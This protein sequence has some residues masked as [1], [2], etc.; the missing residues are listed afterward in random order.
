[1]AAAAA[2]AAGA[3]QH[4]PQRWHKAAHVAG[5]DAGQQ[6][7]LPSRRH[8]R[9]VTRCIYVRSFEWLLGVQHL[10]DGYRQLINQL[11]ARKYVRDQLIG[12]NYPGSLTIFVG[13]GAYMLRTS[14]PRRV[15]LERRRTD[16]DTSHRT[17]DRQQCRPCV[18]ALP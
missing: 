2:G 14:R 7:E 12:P 4:L 8:R 10:G 16:I 9:H 15:A 13:G 5:R 6:G 1:M 3:G 11:I 18:V 17:H